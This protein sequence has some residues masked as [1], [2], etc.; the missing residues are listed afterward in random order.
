V[1]F[2]AYN[3]V[4]LLGVPFSLSIW[5]LENY[6]TQ[7]EEMK[8]MSRQEYVAHLRRYIYYYY[9]YYAKS[10]QLFLMYNDDVGDGFAERVVGFQGVPQCTEE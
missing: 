8:N 2:L 10:Y 3:I 5:Q 6:Q 9:Y 7:L 4:L 1:A